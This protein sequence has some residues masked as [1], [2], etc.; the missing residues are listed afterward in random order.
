VGMSKAAGKGAAL[1]PPPGLKPNASEGTWIGQ[2][3]AATR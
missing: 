2:L 1:Q 3:S